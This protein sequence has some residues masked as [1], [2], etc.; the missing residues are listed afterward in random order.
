M[1]AS[2]IIVASIAALMFLPRAGVGRASAFTQEQ[3]D[4]GAETFRL[5]CAR[6]HGPNGRGI[7]DVYKDLTAPPLIGPGS[8][9]AQ[10]RPYQKVRHCDFR[11]LRDVYEFA[12]SVMPLDQ[13]ASL[14]PQDYWN[15]LAYILDADGMR[16]DGKELNSDSAEKL[17]IGTV[18]KYANSSRNAGPAE[19]AFGSANP[20]HAPGLVGA[21]PNPMQQGPAA[22][23]VGTR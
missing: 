12:S 21:P 22:A 3:V 14:Y 11:N 23:I 18:D 4:K 13:P 5:Q 17:Q 19:A 6:C 15:V 7:S 9:P 2:S 10:P 1:Q 8:L 20:A 16:P